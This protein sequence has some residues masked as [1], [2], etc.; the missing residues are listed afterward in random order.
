[1]NL[2]MLTAKPPDKDCLTPM[3]RQQ[4]LLKC[5]SHALNAPTGSD[6]H[7]HA[8]LCCQDLLACFSDF[9]LPLSHLTP[10]MK[11]IPSSYPVHIWYDNTR[12]AGLQS[13][14]GHMMID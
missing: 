9:Y 12:M 8:M 7:V 1:M 13:G 14:E 2:E 4:K 6:A 10:S 11:V 3:L 5:A